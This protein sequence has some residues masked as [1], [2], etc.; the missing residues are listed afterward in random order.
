[1]ACHSQNGP[2]SC[3]G[4][5]LTDTDDIEDSTIQKC[6]AFTDSGAWDRTIAYDEHRFSHSSWETCTGL[7]LMS[8]MG[9]KDFT[10]VHKT[11][12]MVNM[13][14]NVVKEAH[15]P[16]LQFDQ[17]YNINFQSSF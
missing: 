9:G 8:S 5:S 4:V 16:F 13:V 7:Y 14:V 12:T 6:T 3:G 17:R 1:M 2:I 15:P 11:S 10:D